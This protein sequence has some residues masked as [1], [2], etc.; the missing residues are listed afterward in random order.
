VPNG[1]KVSFTKLSGDPLRWSRDWLGKGHGSITKIDNG[2]YWTVELDFD[3]ESFMTLF[4]SDTSKSLD[5]A[6]STVEEIFDLIE[7]Y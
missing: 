3:A 5:E 1:W 7:E 2:Y 4:D 6:K